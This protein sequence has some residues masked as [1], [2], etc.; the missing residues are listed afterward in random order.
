MDIRQTL[1]PLF[2]LALALPSAAQG[3][4]RQESLFQDDNSLIY[5][6][7]QRREKTLDEL[8]ALGVDVIRSN[9]LWSQVAVHPNSRKWPHGARYPAANWSR[10]DALVR[11]AEARGIA[12]Q[13]TLTGPLPLWASRC[14]GAARIRR[15]CRPKEAEFGRFVAAAAKRYPTVSRWS[16]WNEPN[17]GGWLYPQLKRYHHRAR[18][19]APYLYRELAYT[20]ITHLRANGHARDQILLGETAPLGR[21]YG[22]PGKRSMAPGAF[23]R[24]VLCIDARGRPLRGL[25]ARALHCHKRMKKLLATG[26]AHHPYTRAASRGPRAKVG[27]DDITL[28]KIGRLTSTLQRGAHRRRI[29]GKL[30]IYLTEYGYQTNPPDRYSGVRPSKAAE[31][32]NE[33]DWMAYRMPR[34]KAVAQ[35]ELYDERGGRGGFQTGLRYRSG[36]AKPGLAAYRLPIWVVR[37]SG[38]TSIWGQAR[39]GG[40]SDRIYIRYQPKRGRGWRTYR[41][42]HPNSRGFLRVH[43]RKPAYRW[44]LDWQDAQG[45]PRGLSRP[46]RPR[47]R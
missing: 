13:L 1:I 34:V 47:S 45:H 9:V 30:P 22:S 12:V 24:A 33:S 20:A 4:T 35:Y 40:H 3:S 7:D 37:R 29:R 39:A 44:R 6:G 38:R 46:A 23:V 8:H 32:L 43:T 18:P 28:S 2:L 21:R 17:Q 14:G 31:W 41:M 5:S 25:D 10:W 15:T 26:W 36:K 19:Y 42:V 27:P 11:G 16:V